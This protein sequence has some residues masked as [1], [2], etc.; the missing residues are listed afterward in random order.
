MGVFSIPFEYPTASN[1]IFFVNKSDS[2]NLSRNNRPYS[3]QS[4]VYLASEHMKDRFLIS[5]NLSQN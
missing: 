5:L 3:I 4:H 1:N 2:I